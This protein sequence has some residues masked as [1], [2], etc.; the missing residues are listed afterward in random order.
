MERRNLMKEGKRERDVL[1]GAS[2]REAKQLKQAIDRV[3]F[4]PA[5]LFPAGEKRP[6]IDPGR[7]RSRTN[8]GSEEDVLVGSCSITCSTAAGTN[9]L[10]R[11]WSRPACGNCLVARL[12]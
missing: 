6:S 4:L 10:H 9:S 1:I 12:N 5:L 7:E 8:G 2:R 11:H 3:A